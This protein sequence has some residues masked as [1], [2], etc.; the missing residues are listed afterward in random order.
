[1]AD[2]DSCNVRY[3]LY[4]INTSKEYAEHEWPIDILIAF[5][6]IIFG[7]NMFLTIAKEE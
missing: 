4:G 1:M 6:W 7:A 3:V 2:Y 5:S